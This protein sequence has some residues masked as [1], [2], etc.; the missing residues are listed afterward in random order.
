[1]DNKPEW[2]EHLSAPPADGFTPQLM[3]R[4][5]E[6]SRK[7]T[8]S[9]KPAIPAFRLASLAAGLALV[10]A[11]LMGKEDI[12]RYFSGKSAAGISDAGG[13]F[14]H[15]EGGDLAWWQKKKAAALTKEEQ[16]LA[17]AVV[18]IMT[19]D[20]GTFGRKA[21]IDAYFDPAM[22][23]LKDLLADYDASSPRLTEAYVLE[24]TEDSEGTIFKIGTV[25][26]T[27][28]PGDPGYE[29]SFTMHVNRTSGKI[30]A[31]SVEKT[32]ERTG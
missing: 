29:G 9:G 32:V 15:K 2:E 23:H 18:S 17:G 8:E 7:R 16:T 11:L 28:I 27:G 10:I 22:L 12:V 25:L 26:A 21:G 14:A 6:Q 13:Y 5:A 31:L 30:D 4:I 19:R 3:R 20:I 1:V 24:Q